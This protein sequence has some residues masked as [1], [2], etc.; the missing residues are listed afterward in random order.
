MGF[1]A[2]PNVLARLGLEFDVL[3]SGCCGMA[4]SFGF[5]HE[6]YETSLKIGALVLIPAVRK[7]SKDTLVIADGFS[8]REQ[9][10]Q[11]TDRQGLHLAE[12]IHLAMHTGTHSDGPAR[13]YPE[14][15]I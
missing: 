5:K 12:V 15:A 3:D 4:G 6:H 11:A 13:N 7:A 1:R 14:R 10:A 8:C 2:E 9:I